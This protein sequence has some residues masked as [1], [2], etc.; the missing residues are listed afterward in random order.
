MSRNSQQNRA[1]RKRKKQQRGNAREQRAPRPGI[2]AAESLVFAGIEFAYG[3]S[4]NPESLR[5]TVRQLADL[6]GSRSADPVLDWVSQILDGSMDH[7]FGTDGSRRN[8][9][10]RCAGNSAHAPLG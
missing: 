2:E 6:D 3:P 5:Q 1:A 7:V 9:C 4:A 10:T 8:S